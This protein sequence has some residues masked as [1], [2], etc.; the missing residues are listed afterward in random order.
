MR[1]VPRSADYGSGDC[2]HDRC[3]VSAAEPRCG[4]LALWAHLA[5]D[6]AG[7]RRSEIIAGKRIGGGTHSGVRDVRNTVWRANSSS[8]AGS[9]CT[10]CTAYK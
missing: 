3:F 6:S 1:T 9:T 4:E 2:F 5:S 10:T 7:G 8:A